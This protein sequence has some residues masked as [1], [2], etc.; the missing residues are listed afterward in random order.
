MWESI[1][2]V[3]FLDLKHLLSFPH[4]S[5][6]AVSFWG[7]FNP[8]WLF[9]PPKRLN[10]LWSECNDMKLGRDGELGSGSTPCRKKNDLSPH[11]ERH[12]LD[13]SQ[14]SVIDLSSKAQR[15]IFAQKTWGGLILTRGRLRDLDPFYW[16]FDVHRVN[17]TFLIFFNIIP[18]EHEI[19]I[20]D[21]LNDT[22]YDLC[23]KISLSDFVWQ[24]LLRIMVKK[25]ILVQFLFFGRWNNVEDH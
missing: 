5:G 25:V 22:D 13:S 21:D 10:D 8:A 19:W 1:I 3:L 24:Q 12:H 9:L 2:V 16:Q 7:K 23:A 14:H 18:S 17:K 20:Y 6:L 15:T 4:H 11:R